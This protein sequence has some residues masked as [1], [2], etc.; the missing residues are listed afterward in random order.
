M[1]KVD[2]DMSPVLLDCEFNPSTERKLPTE[3][4]VPHV[5]ITPSDQLLG[6]SSARVIA[7]IRRKER[8]QE[9]QSGPLTQPSNPNGDGRSRA[10]SSDVHESTP[11]NDALGA[12]TPGPEDDGSRKYL[13]YPDRIE[14]ELQIQCGGQTI[15]GSYGWLG[16]ND[17]DGY[18][19]IEKKADVLIRESWK[20]PTDAYYFHF[21]GGH[22]IE[23]RDGERR[24]QHAIANQMQWKSM[25]HK[26]V[27]DFGDRRLERCTLLISREYSM[28]EL[29]PTDLDNEDNEDKD[30]GEDAFVNN[31]AY[32]LRSL[33]K[34][35]IDGKEYLPKIDLD[36]FASQPMIRAVINYSDRLRDLTQDR[37]EKLIWE[38]DSGAKMLFTAFILNRFSMYCF[39]RLLKGGYRDDNLPKRHQEEPYA[40]CK[41]HNDQLNALAE[42]IG[43][44]SAFTFKAQ[45]HFFLE[46]NCVIPI[47][48]VAVDQSQRS[49]D[50]STGPT[51]AVH[52][53]QN[54]RY[55]YTEQK[56]CLFPI[57]REFRCHC[58]IIGSFETNPPNPNVIMVQ[59]C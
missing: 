35:N 56:S 53:E 38:I 27:K 11:G 10:F 50:L 31:K 49:S 14:Y 33:M 8:T 16:L 43:A 19:K 22:C 12:H 48:P 28:F 6:S 42:K 47:L 40:C 36:G 32:E 37:R 55:V 1:V 15:S 26:L 9:P 7:P 20:E 23:T 51:T 45:G 46:P 30:P 34:T 17:A 4:G 29:R 5:T 52:E 41:Y 13:L 39:N 59:Q 44:F 25:C 57:S 2:T 18:L 54:N 24:P 58:I 3:T 21:R